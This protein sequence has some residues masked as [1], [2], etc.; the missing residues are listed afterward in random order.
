MSIADSIING[1]YYETL[2]KRKKGKEEE[3]KRTGR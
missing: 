2:K 3:Q 1:S